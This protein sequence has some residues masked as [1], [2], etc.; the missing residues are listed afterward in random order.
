M[1]TSI[2]ATNCPVWLQLGR[3]GHFQVQKNSVVVKYSQ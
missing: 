2:N 1:H 3:Y